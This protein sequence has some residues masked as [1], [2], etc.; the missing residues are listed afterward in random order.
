MQDNKVTAEAFVLGL[1]NGHVDPAL[2]TDDM[3][4]WASTGGEAYPIAQLRMMVGVLK[5]LFTDDFAMEIEATIAEGDRVA[6]MS[7]SRGTLKDGPVYANSYHFALRFRDGR[8]CEMREYMNS[9][10]VKEMIAPRLMAALT[11]PQ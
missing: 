7:R 3:T 9:G 11:A 4:A 1:A 5:T 2:V 6:V 10:L 8:I